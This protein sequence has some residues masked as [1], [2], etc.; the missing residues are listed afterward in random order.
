MS[1]LS[2][3]GG[4]WSLRAGILP[5]SLLL[6]ALTVGGCAS[7]QSDQQAPSAQAYDADAHVADAGSADAARPKEDLEADGMPAQLPPLRRPRPIPDDPTEPW[8]PNYGTV[9]PIRSANAAD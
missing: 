5:L 1:A 9:R 4:G 7:R 8:S 6:V 3:L 2:R